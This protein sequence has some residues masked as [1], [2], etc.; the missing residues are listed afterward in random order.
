MFAFIVLL[1]MFFK[2]TRTPFRTCPAFFSACFTAFCFAHRTPNKPA[3]N[4]AITPTAHKVTALSLSRS[5]Q[6]HTKGG[7][8]IGICFPILQPKCFIDTSFKLKISRAWAACFYREDALRR[9][10]KGYSFLCSALTGDKFLI[11]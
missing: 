1:A 2:T 6:P 10:K 7:S 9:N 3:T 8:G 5:T 4:R 11:D